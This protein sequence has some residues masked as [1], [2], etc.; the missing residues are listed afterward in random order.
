VQNERERIESL[1]VRRIDMK[2]SRLS[3]VGGCAFY[4][5]SDSVV[6]VGGPLL[7]VVQ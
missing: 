6:G 1:K 7:P 5:L 4:F 3:P 2:N